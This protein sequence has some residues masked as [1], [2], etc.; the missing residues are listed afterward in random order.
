M[1]WIKSLPEGRRQICLNIL[2]DIYSEREV[3]MTSGDGRLTFNQLKVLNSSFSRTQIEG[4]LKDLV[5]IGLVESSSQKARRSFRLTRSG[6]KLVDKIPV[7]KKRIGNAY[8]DLA[9]KNI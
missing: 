2:L 3:D 4:A 9:L 7:E 5:D 8:R 1:S 6:I